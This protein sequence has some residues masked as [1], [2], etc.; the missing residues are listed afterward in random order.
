MI[1][2]KTALFGAVLTAAAAAASAAFAG[3]S[4]GPPCSVATL[5]GGYGLSGSGF[6]GDTPFAVEGRSVYDGRGSFTAAETHSLG[7]TI[8]TPSVTGTYTVNADCTGMFVINGSPALNFTIDQGGTHIRAIAIGGGGVTL[9]IEYSE[10]FPRNSQSD[11][12]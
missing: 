1:V 12:N 2:L 11:G 4:A 8:T 3:S 7:G 9:T 6:I 5:K 10:Q